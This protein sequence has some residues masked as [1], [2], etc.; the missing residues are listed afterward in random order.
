MNK[1]KNIEDCIQYQILKGK[2]QNRIKETAKSHWEKYC[3]SLNNATKLGQVWKEARNM[4]NTLENENSIPNLNQE[5]GTKTTNAQEKADLLADQF[6][7]NSSDQNYSKKFQTNKNIHLSNPNFSS[8]NSTPNQQTND[9]NAT[10]NMSEL[11]IAIAD[12]EQKSSPGPDK[13]TYS[14]LKHL[15]HVGLEK[16]LDFYNNILNNGELPDTWKHAVITPI[17]KPQKDNTL[18]ANYR[19]ISQTNTLCKILEKIITN[20]LHYFLETNNKFNKY[21]TGF[22]KGLST[23]DQLIKLQNEITATM[24]KKGLTVA[25][26]LDFEKAYDMIWK[27]GLLYKCNNLGINGK[28]FNYIKAFISNRTFQVKINNTYSSI[29]TQ[30]NGTPQGSVISA[31]LFLIMINDL[32]PASDDILLSLFADDSATYS[33][34]KNVKKIYKSMQTTLNKISKWCDEWGFKLSPTKSKC[35]V[36]SRNKKYDDIQHTLHINNQK[37]KSENSMMFLGMILDRK[38]NFNEHIT[39]IIDKGKKRLNLMRNLCGTTW[40][41]SINTLLT[42]YRTLIRS[43]IEYGDIVYDNTSNRNKQ[44]LDSLQ[45]QALKICCGSMTG[46]PLEALQNETGELPLELSRLKHQL[47]YYAKVKTNTKHPSQNLITYPPNTKFN[48]KRGLELFTMKT[49]PIFEQQQWTLN[50]NNNTQGTPWINSRI[51]TNETLLHT[52]ENLNTMTEKLKMSNTMINSYSNFLNIYTDGTL[53]PDNTMC[54][55]FLHSNNKQINNTQKF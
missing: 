52:L 33:S 15:P 53:K 37:I 2:T 16:I 28:I 3:N 22:R 7:F 12:T 48:E 5:N 43:I 45:Y 54:I 6:Q 34:G 17:P 49:S 36:F 38:L 13:I 44:K 35:I 31:L 42:I 14:M 9:L 20:R 40:G 47:I 4:N 32:S 30:V 18:P 19:P 27:P 8:D 10:I 46:S 51:T 29:R 26:F 1:T 50:S 55:R 23:T 39:Y 21:Q 25:V 11:K 24:R 41:A